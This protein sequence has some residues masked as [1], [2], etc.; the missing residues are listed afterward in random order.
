MK[1]RSSKQFD[2][3]NV[4]N[5]DKLRVVDNSGDLHKSG[6]YLYLMTSTKI[7]PTR[8]GAAAVIGG[9]FTSF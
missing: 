5:S 2:P 8:I 1:I 9:D 6:T 7:P 3:H 4:S